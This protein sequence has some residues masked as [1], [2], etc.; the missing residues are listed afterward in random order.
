MSRQNLSR[1]NFFG[2]TAAGAVA[3]VSALGDPV[4]AAA[5]AIGIK[6]GDLPDLTIKDVKVYVLKEE[7]R[8]GGAAARPN[9]RVEQFAAV[10]T[11][12]GIEGNYVVPNRY[13]HSN[14]SNLGWL[15][16]AKRVLIG[17]SVLDLPRFTSQFRSNVGQLS[18]AGTID[19]CLWDILGKAVGLPVYRI[20][21]AYRE[22]V[23]AYASSQHLKTVDAF[24][25]D[26]QHAKS[27]GFTAYKI[28]PPWLAENE[29]D[30]K[31]DIEVAKAV[32]KTGGDDM[33][34]LFDRVGAYTREEAMKVG[35]A[36]DRLNYVSFED[37][38]PTDDLEGLAALVQALDVPITMG[39]FTLS[40]YDYPKYIR[41]RALDEVRFIVEN[42]GGISG[43]MK[44]AQLAECFGML[45]QPHNWGSLLD[46][47]AHFHC[48][49]AMPNN[50]WFEM[51]QP[52][53]T[54]DRPYFKD[55]LRID[56][57]GYV[58]APV[59]P[60]LGY[61]IDRNVLDNTLERVET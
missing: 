50:V 51:T 24:I 38:L 56:K 25:A 3:G 45:C 13:S 61:E 44:V 43:G 49:L 8:A 10:I 20:L 52:Q 28:H 42:V 21:G 22:R 41:R 6:R 19:I 18:Y 15:P 26:V 27:Q 36:L 34:L 46:H 32:R 16:Y 23:R 14:W 35:R 47:A 2:A 54:T 7:R 12:S 1:R 60:G 40:P 5:Q 48:E 55:Q 4:R 58:P 39:E 17:K 31:L 29:V 30:Y 9:N 37:A 33:P 57:D 59:K 53:G 11:N